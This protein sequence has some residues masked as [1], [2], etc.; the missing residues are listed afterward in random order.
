MTLEQARKMLQVNQIPFQDMEF[1]CVAEYDNH[2]ILYPNTKNTSPG[3][4]IAL[5]IPSQ[6]SR[7]NLEL[8]FTSAGDCFRFAEL[9]FGEYSF[10][11][12]DIGEGFLEAELLDKIGQILSGNF[13]VIVANDLGRKRWLWDTGFDMKEDYADFAAVLERIQKPKSLWAK[14]SKRRIQYEIYNWNTYRCI[15]K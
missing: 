10:E 4:V 12:F 11:L 2:N 7:K 13:Q 6:N 3:R 14:L 15:L 5:V 9:W 1:S 8:Q